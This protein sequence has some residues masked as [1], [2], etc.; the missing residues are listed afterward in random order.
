MNIKAM[1]KQHKLLF[2]CIPLILLLTL[3]VF[4]GI[5]QYSRYREV[6]SLVAEGNRYLSE[7]DY[8]QAITYYEQAL[9][10]DKKHRGANL[11]MAECY[12]ISGQ[13]VY[14]EAIYQSMLDRNEKDAE[15]YPKLAELYIR[16]GKMDLAR[17]LMA[18]GNRLVKDEGVAEY[19]HKTHPDMPSA[20]HPSG[21]YDERIAVVLTSEEYTSIYYTLD[22]TDPTPQS[23]AYTRP[24]ILRNGETG[25]R[26]IAVNAEGFASEIAVYDY[27][28]DIPDTVVN[29]E[30][31]VV[32]RVIRDT[33]DLYGEDPIYNDDIAQITSLYVIDDSY[34][35]A[36]YEPM[37]SFDGANYAVDGYSRY[38]DGN[39]SLTTLADIKFMPFL[40][41]LVVAYQADLD[42][43]GLAGGRQLK[44]LSLL[45]CGLE[46]GDLVSVASLA[47]LETLSL[48]WN[49]LTDLSPLSPLT[50][51][52]SLSVWGNSV[53]DLTPLAQLTALTY[54][55]FSENTVTDIAPVS[56]L[57][58]L[59]ELWMWSND[60]RVLAPISSLAELEVLM[61]RNNPITDKESV[62]SVYPHL[63]RIDVDLLGLGDDAS[64]GG[65]AQ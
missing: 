59:K 55:D 25:V 17:E 4:L 33:L 61:L 11:G 52:T 1:Y 28:T 24:L 53:T 65:A 51:L 37:L 5:R 15:V 12:E 26:A 56:S 42:V 60:V 64:E 22:G 8:E 13:N 9:H 45:S 35:A 58:A 31:P 62:R 21:T 29:V 46:D 2:I 43:T 54:L 7:M 63:K 18:T 34:L 50:E 41:T 49:G 57:T 10:I 36:N 40:E 38:A 16:Q 30:D 20:N 19:Y 3:G 14:A 47:G 48:G 23:P 44:N 39:G 6:K 27:V 32:E